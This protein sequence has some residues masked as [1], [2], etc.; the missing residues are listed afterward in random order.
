MK[1]MVVKAGANIVRPVKRDSHVSQ[2]DRIVTPTRI[3]MYDGAPHVFW[4]G[5]G[6]TDNATT[7]DNVSF[8][9]GARGI[10]RARAEDDPKQAEGITME[11]GALIVIPKGARYS[12]IGGGS[13]NRLEATRAFTVTAIRFVSSSGNICV[14]W[15]GSGNKRYRAAITDEVV[16]ANS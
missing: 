15:F 14:E 8:E 4:K 9:I 13:G 12:V 7:L 2:R 1:K 11:P 10:N 5:N 6:T 16:K 3:A